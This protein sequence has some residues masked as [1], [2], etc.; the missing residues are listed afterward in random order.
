VWVSYFGVVG[1]PPWLAY[2]LMPLIGSIDISLGI[3]VLFYPVRAA[4]L[5]MAFWGFLTSTIRPLAGEP[6]W[7]WIERVPNWG[8]PL[9]LLYL[10][11]FGDLRG[12][13]SL[14]SWGAAIKTWLQ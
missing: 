1:I 8:V 9:A 12:F 13:R 14:R 10:R 2:K 3:L 6:V 4:L 11:G 7:E 5:Y